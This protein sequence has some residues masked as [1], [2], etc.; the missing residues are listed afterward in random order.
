M[1]LSLYLQRVIKVLRGLPAPSDYLAAYFHDKEPAVERFCTTCSQVGLPARQMAGRAD[2]ERA[3]WAVLLV[4][5]IIYVIDFIILRFTT[6]FLFKWI[7][8]LTSMAG[9]VFAV[10]S[11][12]YTLIR[13]SIRTNTCPTCGGTQVIPIDSPKAKELLGRS[14]GK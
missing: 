14:G 7:F 3:L 13:V 8:K 6:F 4:L 10:L 5:T 1:K 12:A 9:K 2:L 11:F